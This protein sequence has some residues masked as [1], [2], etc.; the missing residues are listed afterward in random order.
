MWVRIPLGVWMSVSCE[1]CVLSGR[2]L[3]DELITRPEEFYRLWYFVMCDIG[4]SWMRRAW[5]TGRVVA[6]KININSVFSCDYLLSLL[7]FR[8]LLVYFSY[9]HVLSLQLALWLLC[10]QVNIK[11]LNWNEMSCTDWNHHHILLPGTQI[12][13]SVKLVFANW[14]PRFRFLTDIEC[15]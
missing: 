2:G 3:C 12:I 5:P 10:H 6:P 1:C 9:V 7:Y 4:T 11:E 15:S 14:K 8:L 13:S